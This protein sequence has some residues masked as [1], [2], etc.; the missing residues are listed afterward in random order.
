MARL[1]AQELA[2]VE[3]WARGRNEWAEQM[4]GQNAIKCLARVDKLQHIATNYETQI[5]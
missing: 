3:D 2:G 1:F 4:A 5:R